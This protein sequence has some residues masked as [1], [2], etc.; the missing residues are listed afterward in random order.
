MSLLKLIEKQP[1]LQKMTFVSGPEVKTEFARTLLRTLLD[2][3]ESLKWLF[4]QL[5][6]ADKL[7]IDEDLFEGIK[8]S[9]LRYL[10]LSCPKICF[11]SVLRLQPS[12]D[13]GYINR[14]L[15]FLAVKGEMDLVSYQILVK[16]FTDLDGLELEGFLDVDV[17][18][19][20]ITKYSV[21]ISV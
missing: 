2:K 4:M 18:F 16:N 6:G 10:R 11:D 3:C 14:H 19:K 12:T 1:L 8:C 13:D 5:E 20:Y 9:R 15:R 7:N 17:L 21:S